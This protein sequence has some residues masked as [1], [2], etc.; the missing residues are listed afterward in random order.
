MRKRKIKRWSKVKRRIKEIISWP[1]IIIAALVFKVASSFVGWIKGILITWGVIDGM[2]SNYLYKEEK[3]FP[4]QFLRYMR[5]AANLSGI[6][7]PVIPIV[8]NVGDGIYSL[9][10]YRKKAKPIENLSRYGRIL[11]GTLL[12]LLS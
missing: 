6:F 12:A 7:N 8:W 3:F 2:A 11:N 10:L 5:I 4:Y 9:Y 1:L